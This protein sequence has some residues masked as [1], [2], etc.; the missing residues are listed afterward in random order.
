MFLKKIALKDF[1]GFDDLNVSFEN[2]LG[3]VRKQTILLGQNGTGK[4]NILKAI[5]IVSAG[6]ESFVELINDTS[7]WVKYGKKEAKIEA[8]LVTQDNQERK[9]ALRIPM[10]ANRNELLK[11]NRNSLELLDAAIAHTERN[12]FVAAYGASRRNTRQAEFTSSKERY[13]ISNRSASVFSLFNP[14]SQLVSLTSWAMNAEYKGGKSQIKI[15]EQTLNYFLEGF[16]FHGIDKLNK[17]LLFKE[18]KSILSLEQLSDGYQ[19]MAAWIG[20]LLYRLTETFG[21]QKTPLNARG[22]LLIDEID[23]HLHP[24]WQRKL[25]DFI[26][27]KLPNMQLIATTHSPLTAQQAAEGELYALQKEDYK[28]SLVAFAGNPQNMLVH[29]L[30]LSP[31]FGVETDESFEVQKKKESYQLMKNKSG[32]STLDKK[33]LKKM[34]EELRN[35]PERPLTMMT[36][37]RHNDLL[38]KIESKL[39]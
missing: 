32:K 6:S 9:I 28:I 11:L 21:D 29:Q 31:V 25:L 3:T 22:I 34:G 15:I 19:N 33:N 8:V 36:A 7:E 35:I 20:D 5:A 23:L 38:R 12:Y 39:K 2:D 14:D 18:G 26:H 4:S 13:R 27:L 16:K 1:K 37:T 30:L 24:R 10:K 17:T